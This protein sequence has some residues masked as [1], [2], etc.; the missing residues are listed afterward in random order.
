MGPTE[1]QQALEKYQDVGSLIGVYKSAA[2]GI[3]TLREIQAQT[4]ELAQQAM[5]EAGAVHHKDDYG[6][7]GWSEPKSQRLDRA[8]WAQA[9]EASPAPQ[10]LQDELNR[11]QARLEEAQQEAGCLYTPEPRFFI[12]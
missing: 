9:V 1:L 10:Q 7:C 2:A 11:A 8:R 5:S 12:R 4:L 6:T 3:R